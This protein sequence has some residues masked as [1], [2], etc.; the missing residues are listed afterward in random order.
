VSGEFDA[1]VPDMF[2]R[3]VLPVFLCLAIFSALGFVVFLI[4]RKLK[5]AW[6]GFGDLTIEFVITDPNS[7]KPIADSR[8]SVRATGGFYDEFDEDYKAPFILRADAN[9]VA[10]RL[11]HNNRRIGW[12][13]P[14]RFTDAYSFY[15][16]SWNFQVSAEGYETS[17][18][19]FLSEYPQIK[20]RNGDDGD[21][22]IVRIELR[23]K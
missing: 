20:E 15:T 11:L 14:L 22:L 6:V 18:L 3:K 9:G 1:G 4:D 2:R 5:I 21:R 10:T 17:D 8:I 7:G 16:P 12:Q 19:F 13:S 23:K